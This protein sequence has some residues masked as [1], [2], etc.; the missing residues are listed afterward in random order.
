MCLDELEAMKDKIRDLINK[1]DQLYNDIQKTT[2]NQETKIEDLMNQIHDMNNQ[3]NA[4]QMDKER[5]IF[6]NNEN[7]TKV[8]EMDVQLSN[9]DTTIAVL[10]EQLESNEWLNVC[11]NMSKKSVEIQV[12]QKKIK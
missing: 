5:L 12:T 8:E 11:K 2:E 7:C 4:L 1:Q 6:E 10:Q 3:M 9:A